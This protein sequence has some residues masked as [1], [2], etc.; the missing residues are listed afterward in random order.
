M[1]IYSHP[2]FS[3]QGRD[4]PG[5]EHPN[6]LSRVWNLVQETERVYSRDHD[7]DPEIRSK[8]EDVHNYIDTI[9]YTGPS[10]TTIDEERETFIDRLTYRAG[11]AAV[12]TSIYAA[13]AEGFAL[14]RPPGHHAHADYTHGFCIFNN[15]AIAAKQLLKDGERV[16]VLDLD[17]HHGCGTE[18]LLKKEPDAKMISLYQ[19]GTKRDWPANNHFT[20]A[21]NCDHIPI[22]GEVHDKRY[23]KIF[24]KILP[25]IDAFQPTIIG[26]SLGLDTFEGEAYAWNLTGKSL[27]HIRQRLKGRRIF[28]ILEGG[29]TEIA[30]EQGLAAFIEDP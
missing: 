6:R 23:C 1:E 9:Q 2:I 27:Q 7:Q 11:I 13:Q 25:T 8:I 12:V 20:Y 26:V 16:L 3:V 30:I 21:K 28:A 10:Y 24:D 22:K 29:Y 18:E 4:F 17:I 15:M 14:V 5:Q 19:R